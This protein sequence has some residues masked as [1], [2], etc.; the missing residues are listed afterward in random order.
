MKTISPAR[1]AELQRLAENPLEPGCRG[2]ITA[3]EVAILVGFMSTKGDT[4]PERDF[5]KP[6]AP[7]HDYL[8]VGRLVRYKGRMYRVKELFVKYDGPGGHVACVPCRPS[9]EYPP[10][11]LDA[12]EELFVPECSGFDPDGGVLGCCAIHRADWKIDAQR[13]AMNDGLY[14]HVTKAER[15]G[16]TGG[17]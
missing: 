1:L 12:G 11:D 6:G 3:E 5:G 16:M 8:S 10:V 13:S 7:G 4:P 14:I 15:V 9:E 2:F 17:R